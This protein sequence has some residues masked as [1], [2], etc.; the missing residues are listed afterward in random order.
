MPMQSINPANEQVLQTF[1]E[2]TD[3][4]VHEKLDRAIA[5]FREW[6]AGALRAPG[7]AGA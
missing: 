3:S 2:H 5:T 1:E 4:Q 6:R 7:G